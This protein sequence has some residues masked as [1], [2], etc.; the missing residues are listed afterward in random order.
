MIDT[1]RTT[2]D[3]ADRELVRAAVNNYRGVILAKF[4][5][6]QSRNEGV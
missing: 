3:L 5:R 2:H 1:L 4:H 6:E